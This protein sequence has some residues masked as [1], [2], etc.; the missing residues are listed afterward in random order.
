MTR[1]KNDEQVSRLEGINC[2]LRLALGECR[3][4]LERLE[5]LMRQSKQDTR[6]KDGDEGS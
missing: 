3:E 4:Q 2:E 5:G 6:R 1:E